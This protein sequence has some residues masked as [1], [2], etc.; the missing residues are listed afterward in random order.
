MKLDFL[1][2]R[3]SCSHSHMAMDCL[4]GSGGDDDQLVELVGEKVGVNLDIQ[5]IVKWQP[6]NPLDQ[7]VN[8]GVANLS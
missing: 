6:A 2:I 8:D 7:F 1:S 5:V 3:A 4:V